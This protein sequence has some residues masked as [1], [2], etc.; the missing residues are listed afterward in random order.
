MT[1]EN[2]KVDIN[3]HENDIDTLKKQNV[4]DLLSI[5]ELYSKLEEL[6]EKITQFKYI[7]NTLVKKIKK[8]YGNLKKIILDENIQVQLDNKIDDFNIKLTHDIETIN[9]QLT[10][11]IETINSQL[12]TKASNGVNIVTL[13]RELKKDINNSLE[14]SEVLQYAVDN[15]GGVFFPVG[16]YKLANTIILKAQSDVGINLV[17]ENFKD[18]KLILDNTNP[19]T[20]MFEIKTSTK[21][22]NRYKYISNLNLVADKAKMQSIVRYE[23]DEINTIKD[24]GIQ[25]EKCNIK[26][27]G[28]V[29]DLRDCDW[30]G[31]SY[32]KNCEI[33]GNGI[34]KIY[35]KNKL[36]N[37]Y[38]HST[39][40]LVIEDVH[41]SGSSNR[42][43]SVIYLVGCQ[44][45]SISRVTLEGVIRSM[46]ID[47][48]DIGDG[49]VGADKFTEG[50]YM[51]LKDSSGTIEDC[52]FE[53][54]STD[55]TPNAKSIYIGAESSSGSNPDLTISFKGG[56]Y[57]DLSKGMQIGS[58]ISNGTVHKVIMEKY[59]SYAN[60]PFV[61]KEGGLLTIIDLLTVLPMHFE[62]MFNDSRIKVLNVDTIN[63]ASSN[64]TVG[65]GLFTSK[66]TGNILYKY[67]GGYQDNNL[68][69][70]VTVDKK[71][72]NEAKWFPNYNPK[73]G[74]TLIFKPDNYAFRFAKGQ[75]W[76]E[77]KKI[78]TSIMRYRELHK[79]DKTNSGDIKIIKY[80]KE[81]ENEY[82][83]I[84]YGDLYNKGSL[85]NTPNITNYI[86][87]IDLM[88]IEGVCDIVLDEKYSNNISIQTKNVYE[89]IYSCQTNLEGTWKKGDVVLMADGKNKTIF[90]SDGTTRPI[91]ITS[92]ITIIDNK[93]L[94]IESLDDFITLFEGDKIKLSTNNNEFKTT[95]IEINYESVNDYRIVL[96]DKLSEDIT[97]INSIINNEPS[98]VVS[99]I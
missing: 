83:N 77:G 34:A 17:G 93:T 63:N 27:T 70:N 80:T 86:E 28:Y 7:D 24:S 91:N 50:V 72:V 46:Q 68:Y 62:N 90:T 38:W 35:P 30:I 16:E 58:G 59:T 54:G 99:P 49:F 32:I 41:F 74:N 1:K 6:G 23:D 11:D 57:F 29:L 26:T 36:S 39:S 81:Y 22:A 37:A 33:V 12:G 89:S 15:Y 88:Y 96:R 85:T 4:N 82:L 73:Y 95:I 47:A 76:I 87:L 44:N 21:W 13:A 55:N 31:N 66:I 78:I 48:D 64:S 5:K 79:K 43:G 53:T 42:R 98:K 3:K 2:N 20:H 56:G 75:V 97:V 25:I 10:N 65:N 71:Y 14:C 8:E 69:K 51:T 61:L 60:N 67:T 40:N 45:T 52:W 94:K 9:S 18:T 19:D 92:E 84:E